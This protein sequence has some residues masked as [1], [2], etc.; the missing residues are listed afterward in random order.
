M[1]VIALFQDFQNYT[2]WPNEHTTASVVSY[3]SVVHSILDASDPVFM[4]LMGLIVPSCQNYTNSAL[5][6]PLQVKPIQ[7]TL[8]NIY[9][10]SKG[11]NPLRKEKEKSMLTNGQLVVT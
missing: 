10:K 9:Y 5:T 3:L 2:E 7:P 4:K 11:V 8:C 6:R 1:L